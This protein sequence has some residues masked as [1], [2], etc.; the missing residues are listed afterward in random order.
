M[1]IVYL[2]RRPI[3][4]VNAH[5]VQIVKMSEA[6]GKLGHNV[7]L[8]AHRGD[9]DARHVYGRYGVDP[10]FAIENFPLRSQRLRKLRFCAHMLRHPEVRSADLFFG[11][12]IFSLALAARL[13]K[14]VIYEAHVIPRRGSLSWR[15]LDRM[16]ASKNFSHLVCVTSTL[17]DTYRRKFPSLKGK[18]IVVV[19]NA[20]SEFRPG[21][22][23]GHWPGR[24]GA[25]QIGFIGRPFVGKGIELMVK[26]AQKLPDHDFHVVGASAEDLHWIEE[27]IPSNLHLHGYQPHGKLGSY[28]SKFDVAVAPYGSKV[29]NASRVESAAITSP[30]KLLEYMSTGLPSIVSDLP[31]VR[32]IVR[33]EDEVTLLVPPGD[34]D[35]FIDAVRRLVEDVELRGRMGK[36]AR[37][38]YLERHT[39]EARARAVLGALAA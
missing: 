2:A 26:A 11:R 1:N 4:S 13:G 21:P 22:S 18:P 29:M 9:D 33:D 36:A 31:G 23:L 30:L 10:A 19:P 24:Q 28:C 12:D 35:A 39:V 25:A 16:F 5:S 38:R 20:A 27:G 15:L 34:E 14:P 8:L 17:A 37:K 3:P 7:L 32:D 6:F